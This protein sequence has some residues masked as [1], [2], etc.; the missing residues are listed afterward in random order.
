MS[1]K[2]RVT[3]DDGYKE[4]EFNNYASAKMEALRLHEERGTNFYVEQII[5]VFYTTWE[6]KL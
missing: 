6:K 4:S 2:Y 5:T 3:N 1:A